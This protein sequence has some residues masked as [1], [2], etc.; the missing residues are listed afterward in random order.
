MTQQ[1]F[2][3][4]IKR[5]VKT[6]DFDYINRIYMAAGEMDKDSFC[7]EYNT[8]IFRSDIVKALVD[9]CEQLARSINSLDHALADQASQL[10]A[11]RHNMSSMQKEIFDLK[12][13]I[14]LRDEKILKIQMVQDAVEK[15]ID[16]D[17]EKAVREAFEKAFGELYTIRVRYE[18]GWELNDEEILWLIQHAEE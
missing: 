5:E 14:V 9:H 10:D 3:T 7:A 2:E 13:Q 4:R 8:M 17:D 16:L 12:S 1:E 6:E 15:H 11:A 18:N